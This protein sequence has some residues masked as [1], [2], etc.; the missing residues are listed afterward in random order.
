M[1]TVVEVIRQLDAVIPLSKAGGWDAVGLQV[2]DPAGDVATIGVCHEV[3]VDL[4]DVLV[5]DPVDL[6][7][8][9][10]PLLFRST[11]R[12]VAGTGASGRAYRLARHGV[13]V[14]AVHTAYD[15]APGGVA[16]ALAAAVGI[17]DA[18]GFGPNWGPDAVKV[19]TFVPEASLDAVASAMAAA[20]A[21]TIGQY[22]GCSFRSEGLGAFTPTETA[23]PAA[24]AIGR[25][26][27]EPETRLEMIAPK[28]AA[29]AVV[30][31]LVSH[32]PYEEPAFD[33]YDVKANAGFIGR[34]GS[35]VPAALGELAEH[36]ATALSSTPRVAG[37]SNRS[38]S[39]VAVVPGSGGGFVAAAAQVADVLVTGDVSHHQARDALDRGLAVVDVGHVPGERP[40]VARL[41]AAVAQTGLPVRNLLDIDPD[42]WS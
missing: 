28:G 7:V 33:V 16:D 32:H 4:V 15:V 3:T 21:G 6:L 26:N 39:R 12:F 18:H 25:P 23:H 27:L 24:G 41:Y 30:A 10:H 40:G 42:P 9:Y 34:Y 13:A 11:R 1:P 37:D 2:G 29:D 36:A 31:A 8:V 22:S 35:I 5:A 19:V 17:D 14:A 20:G 38:I